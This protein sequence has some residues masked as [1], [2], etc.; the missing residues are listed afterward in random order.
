M[1]KLIINGKLIGECS[2]PRQ[3]GYGSPA[4][5]F[6]MKE[7][8]YTTIEYNDILSLD[9]PVYGIDKCCDYIFELRKK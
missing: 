4:Y 6:L 7:G 1:N 2:R 3:R 5:V 8:Y 9:V